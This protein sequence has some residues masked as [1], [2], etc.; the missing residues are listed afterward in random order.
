MKY[1]KK[2]V[3]RSANATVNQACDYPHKA[4][5]PKK[6][7]MGK[8]LGRSA[9]NSLGKFKNKPVSPNANAASINAKG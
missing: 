9:T 6:T 5:G 2:Q 3:T 4:G 8:D 7:D 1:S